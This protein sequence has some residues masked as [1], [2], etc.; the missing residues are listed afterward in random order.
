[1]TLGPR[2]HVKPPIVSIV[3]INLPHDCPPPMLHPPKVY[4]TQPNLGSGDDLEIVHS[5]DVCRFPLQL[6]LVV[7]RHDHH[8]ERGINFEDGVQSAHI[9]GLEVGQ[10]HAN[11]ERVQL[12]EVDQTYVEGLSDLVA[13]SDDGVN[14]E[15]TG[16]VV[17][18][19]IAVL[20][21]SRD[22]VV[23]T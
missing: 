2:A 22:L 18:A 11:G 6:V 19:I 7:A 21:L 20:V 1:V 5:M 13:T 14:R 4:I 23:G 8:V 10:N 15:Y 16:V 3:R 9:D 12:V 17:K